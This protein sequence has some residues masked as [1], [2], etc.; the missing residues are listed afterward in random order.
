MPNL[1]SKG[2]AR[3]F[4]PRY[5]YLAGPIMGCTEGEAKNW[6]GYVNQLLEPHHIYGVSPLRCEPLIGEKYDLQYADPRFGTP[7]AIAAKNRFDVRTCDMAIC[8]LPKPEPG[9][10]ISYGTMGEAFWS[11]AEDKMVVLVTDDPLV[12]RHPVIDSIRGWKLL[13]C[14]VGDGLHFP[15]VDAAL[16]AAAEICI[17]VLGAYTGGKNV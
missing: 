6:R 7:R 4:L 11:D 16:K 5:V 2:C 15:T 12:A 13:A 14:D 1:S 9:R 3:V 8:F 17:G 10:A